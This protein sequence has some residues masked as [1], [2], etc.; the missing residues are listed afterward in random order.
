MGSRI[1]QRV[2]LDS[3]RISHPPTHLPIQPP[4]QP[5]SLQPFF[6]FFWGGDFTL[7]NILDYTV[8]TTM[9]D[10]IVVDHTVDDMG[11]NDID[12]NVNDAKDNIVD[13]RQHH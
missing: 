5:P 8:D 6:C 11:D 1:G 12:K 3:T 10:I 2:A 4:S 7:Y 9:N 13:N